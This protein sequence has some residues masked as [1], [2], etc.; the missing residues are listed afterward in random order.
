MLYRTTQ[1]ID[2]DNQ[3]PAY[4]KKLSICLNANGFSFSEISTGGKLLTVAQVE[5]IEPTQSLSENINALRSFFADAQ[6]NVNSYD[7]VEQILIADHFVWI[8]DSLYEAGNEKQYLNFMNPLRLGMSVAV[9]HSD[10]IGAHMIFAYSSIVADAFKIVVPRIKT[11]T[12]HS[13]LVNDHLLK[14]SQT[15][16]VIVMNVRDNELDFVVFNE[17]QLLLSNSYPFSNTDELLYHAINIMK[18]LRIETPTLE[19]SICGHVD[20]SLFAELTHY[21]PN[22]TLYNGMSLTFAN[23]AMQQFHTYREPLILS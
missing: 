14:R 16:P 23:P 12:H 8:P 21:F 11:R 15:K 3:V 17:G 20:R 10:L 22:V 5:A 19:L 4:E 7:H 13:K 6:M 9:D 1:I 18:N 2:S